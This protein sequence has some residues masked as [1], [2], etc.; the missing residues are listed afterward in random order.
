MPFPSGLSQPQ[1]ARVQGT[2]V[3]WPAPGGLQAASVWLVLF[4]ALQNT[5]KWVVLAS[6]KHSSPGKDQC[7]AKCGGEP[8]TY[9]LF[10]GA[11]AWSATPGP[12]L[13]PT[14]PPPHLPSQQ[15]LSSASPPEALQ[16]L[17]DANGH[18]RFLLPSFLR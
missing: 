18:W 2:A 5:W 3:S 10:R 13:W 15:A 16:M 1:L 9:S 8:R 7:C 4:G 6:S 11:C 17:G 14:A 12:A